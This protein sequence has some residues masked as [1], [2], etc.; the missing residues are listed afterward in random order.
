MAYDRYIA[1]CHPLHFTLIMKWSTCIQMAAGAWLVGFLHAALHTGN[2]FSMTFCSNIINQFFC[3]VPQLIKLFCS[4]FYLGETWVL[5]FGSCLGVGCLS[6]IILSY[7][8]IFSTVLRMPSVERREKAFSTCIPH[9]IVVCVFIS[10]SLLA[11]LVLPAN[12]PSRL[13]E[14]FTVLYALVPSLL[15]PI[16]YSM[17]NKDVKAA[18]WKF[19]GWRN[20]SKK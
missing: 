1:I 19:L 16:V 20:L 12:S 17:R 5:V 3:E 14:I 10:S 2:I 13:D 8:R 11:H 15:N 7:V 18:F 6:F 4:D 9:L